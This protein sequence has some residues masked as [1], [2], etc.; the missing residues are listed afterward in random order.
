MTI[1]PV[2]DFVARLESRG[3]EPRPTGPESWESRCPAHEGNRRNL[4]I[5][6]GDDGRA[7]IHCHHEPRCSPEGIVHAL[8]ITLADLYPSNPGNGNGR[9]SGNRRGHPGSGSRVYQTPEAALARIIRD[10]GPPSEHWTYHEAD[11][12]ESFRVYRFDITNPKTGQAD[13]TYR[14]VHR[15]SEGWALGDPPGLLPLYR[16]PGLADATRVFLHEGEKPADLAH[17]LEIRVTTSATAR[18]RPT[19]PTGARWRER[20][21]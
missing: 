1:D 17:H 6:R 7:L 19:R 10:H 12:S 14:P 8:G 5:R 15:T 4:S 3:W 2:A 21:S 9:P 11:G 20:M 16:L 13:K 18:S